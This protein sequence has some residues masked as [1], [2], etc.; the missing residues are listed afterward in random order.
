MRKGWKL[1]KMDNKL[2]EH[3]ENICNLIHDP[4]KGLP[5]ELFYFISRFTPLVNVDLL[6]KNKHGNTLLTWRHDKFYGPGWHIPGG[7]IRFKESFEQRI[8]KVARIELGCKVAFNSVP[9]NIETIINKERDIRGHF[10]SLL[11]HC[12]LLDL[13]DISRKF[14]LENPEPGCWDWHAGAPSNLIKQ[15]EVYRKFIN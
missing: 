7:I 15:H 3:L 10:I 6:I 11:F 2:S 13:P 12:E 1:K 4:R 14:N 5:D 9:L 8:H